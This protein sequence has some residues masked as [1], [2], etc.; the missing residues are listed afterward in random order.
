MFPSKGSTICKKNE[1]DNLRLQTSDM[2]S[3]FGISQ[4]PHLQ[5]AMAQ[6]TRVLNADQ[7]IGVW[8]QHVE[9][10]LK[11]YQLRCILKKDGAPPIMFG[12]VYK[13]HEYY[14]IL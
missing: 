14:S 4:S 10:V 6:R 11:E 5:T 13:P 9:Q 8:I 1:S 2:V 7:A 3:F 12:K